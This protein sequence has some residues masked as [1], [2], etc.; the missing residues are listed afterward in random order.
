[1]ERFELL[2]TRPTLEMRWH[3]K[4][5]G[6][7]ALCGALR[8]QPYCWVL[9][10]LVGKDEVGQYHTGSPQSQQAALAAGSDTGHQLPGLP[11]GKEKAK[12]PHEPNEDTGWGH[13]ATVSPGCS[14]GSLSA[15]AVSWHSSAPRPRRKLVKQHAGASGIFSPRAAVSVAQ[16]RRLPSFASL[17]SCFRHWERTSDGPLGQASNHKDSFAGLAFG[18]WLWEE[19]AR[20]ASS[21]YG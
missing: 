9:A 8:A 10:A 17:H 11:D 2:T 18:F 4:A 5:P 1:M 16:F 15:Q 14:P 12:W 13:R 20:E 7:R 21:C 3:L 6:L 19:T